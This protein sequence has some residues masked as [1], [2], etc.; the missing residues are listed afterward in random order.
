[1]TSPSANAELNPFA[2][3]QPPKQQQQTT[4]LQDDLFGLD[5]TQP[6]QTFNNHP[7]STGSSA[8]DDLLMLSGANPFIQNIVNQQQYS[9]QGPT[10]MNLFG[11]G[12]G[13]QQQQQQ[14][15]NLFQQQQMPSNG[16]FNNNQNKFG[17]TIISSCNEII[18]Y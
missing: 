14:P 18:L 17:K 16:G 13:M 3:G 4:T 11:N 6:T 9:T 8:S 12:G 15:I 2:N 1:V 5:L 7:T 10:G